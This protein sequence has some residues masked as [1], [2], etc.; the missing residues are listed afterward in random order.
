MKQPAIFNV[1]KW[2]MS[3]TGSNLGMSLSFSECFVRLT[4]GFAVDKLLAFKALME[5]R[6]PHWVG[7]PCKFQC[8]LHY[9]SPYYL[10]S[11]LLTDYKSVTDSPQILPELWPK[12]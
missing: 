7:K 3:V 10:T 9:R 8:L 1:S 12:S 4:I 11:V 5:K 2:H 6:G